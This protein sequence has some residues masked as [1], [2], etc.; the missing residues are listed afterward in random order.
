[1]VHPSMDSASN[2]GRCGRA[3]HRLG[4]FRAMLIWSTTH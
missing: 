1:L 4:A 3:P 2:G